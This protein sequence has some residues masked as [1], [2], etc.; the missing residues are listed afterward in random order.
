MK[1]P[2]HASPILGTG[3]G[4]APVCIKDYARGENVLQRADPVFTERRFN[5]IPVRLVIDKDGKVK[6]IH[7]SARFPIRQKRLPIPC[8]SGASGLI[9][10][11]DSRSRLKPA[12]CSGALHRE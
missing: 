1:L 2:A 5:P 10:A 9:C 11:M 12:S 7:F 6:H 3:G 4:D 8:S